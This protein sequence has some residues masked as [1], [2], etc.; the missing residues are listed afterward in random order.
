MASLRKHILFYLLH[1]DHPRH[2]H[3]GEL[4]EV[5]V[6]HYRLRVSV[7]DDAYSCRAVS[8]LVKLVLELASEIGALEIMD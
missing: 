5:R 3:N 1:I 4:A 8:E 2:G 7:A 6:Y